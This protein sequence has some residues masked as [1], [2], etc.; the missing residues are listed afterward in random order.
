MKQGLGTVTK[1]FSIATIFCGDLNAD[2]LSRTY[3]IVRESLVSVYSLKCPC[4]ASHPADEHG[5]IEFCNAVSN[6]GAQAEPLFTT[7]KFRY[8]HVLSS[9][10]DDLRFCS[11]EPVLV[12]PTSESFFTPLEN[13]L[14]Y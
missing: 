1:G 2:P 10:S 5:V 14:L 12:C 7:W 11:C 13:P 9:S 6:G 4:E 8:V 3:N